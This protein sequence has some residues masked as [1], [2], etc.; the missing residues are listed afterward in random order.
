MNLDK[1]PC[2]QAPTEPVQFSRYPVRRFGRLLVLSDA[3]VH[4]C[5]RCRYGWP[6]PA[7][8][9]AAMREQ[10]EVASR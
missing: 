7:Q 8:V 9:E 2:C 6:D 4:I 1:S 3:T 5:T 10:R